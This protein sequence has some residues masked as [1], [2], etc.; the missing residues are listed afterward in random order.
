M[1]TTSLTQST[2]MRVL[3]MIG[4]VLFASACTKKE[5]RNTVKNASSGAACIG[6]PSFCG[7]RSVKVYS[8]T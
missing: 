7:K 2:P 3:I 4:I 8:T 1:P 6:A 5:T